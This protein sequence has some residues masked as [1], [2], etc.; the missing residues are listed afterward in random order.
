MR[1]GKPWHWAALTEFKIRR[2]AVELSEPVRT[3]PLA[4]WF[5]VELEEVVVT[6]G[7]RPPDL[8]IESWHPDRGLQRQQTPLANDA[9]LK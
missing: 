1:R 2:R 6:S 3:D 7:G 4:G 5:R 9:P 8:V